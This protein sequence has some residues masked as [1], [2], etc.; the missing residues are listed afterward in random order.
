LA[1]CLGENE[2][3][4]REFPAEWRRAMTELQSQHKVVHNIFAAKGPVAERLQQTAKGAGLKPIST[5]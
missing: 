4:E 5:Q 3:L 2:R 1:I